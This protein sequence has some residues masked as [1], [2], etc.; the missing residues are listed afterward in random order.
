MQSLG[1][2]TSR[3]AGQRESGTRDLRIGKLPVETY[4]AG[5]GLEL[6]GVALPL[7]KLPEAQHQVAGASV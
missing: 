7:E 4:L 5:E 6:E 1:R 3:V 2:K